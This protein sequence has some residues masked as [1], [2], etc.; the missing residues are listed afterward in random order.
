MEWADAEPC[1]LLLLRSGRRHYHGPHAYVTGNA[2]R[3]I[4]VEEGE[5]EK[6][7]VESRDEGTGIT[8]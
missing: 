3:A 1:V 5:E 8:H 2:A 4:Q 7:A 6:K